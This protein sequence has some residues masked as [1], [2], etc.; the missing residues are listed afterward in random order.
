VFCV[1]L[2][3]KKVTDV[4]VCGHALQWFD[5]SEKG[6]IIFFR[7]FFHPNYYF[8]I[9]NDFLS[10]RKEFEVQMGNIGI[11]K[12]KTEIPSSPY[13]RALY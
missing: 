4:L 3:V 6:A 2:D 8:N 11:L 1:I 9:Y 10:K 7:F 5:T 12:N 13:P